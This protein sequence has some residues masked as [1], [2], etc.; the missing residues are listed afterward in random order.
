MEKGLPEEVQQALDLL[1]VIGKE[2][3]VP[4]QLDPRDDQDTVM[5][6]F[7]LINFIVEDGSPAKR[8]WRPSTGCSPNGDK[9]HKERHVEPS[10]ALEPKAPGNP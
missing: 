1:R 4:G 5:Q 6:L 8:N 7:E 9:I 10:R 3:A 2:S